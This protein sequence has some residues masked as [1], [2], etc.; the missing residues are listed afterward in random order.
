[1][2]MTPISEKFLQDSG[3][4]RTENDGEWF[5]LITNTALLSVVVVVEIISENIMSTTSIGVGENTNKFAILPIDYEFQLLNLIRS[6]KG[7]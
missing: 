6:L 4:K 5:L 3:F 7:E 2:K 1:M